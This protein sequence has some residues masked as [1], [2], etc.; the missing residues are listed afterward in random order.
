MICDQCATEMKPVVGRRLDPEAEVHLWWQC[1]RCDRLSA[2]VALP[3][4]LAEV[5]MP[6]PHKFC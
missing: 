1:V 6:Q 3:E 2:P 4:N 5:A